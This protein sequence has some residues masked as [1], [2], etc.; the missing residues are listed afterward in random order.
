MT[1]RP[2]LPT[3]GATTRWSDKRRA[4]RPDLPAIKARHKAAIPPKGKHY[5]VELLAP[6]FR[7]GACDYSGAVGPHVT[8]QKAAWADFDAHSHEDVAA[9]L[10]EVERLR[11]VLARIAAGVTTRDMFANAGIAR[12]A[13]EVL[14]PTSPTWATEP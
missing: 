12:E 10:A 13:L 7:C 6:R 1:D 4:D 11:A 5:V 3:H 14:D 8:D 2:D 9:L